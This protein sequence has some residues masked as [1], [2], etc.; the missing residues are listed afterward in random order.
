MASD[1][2]DPLERLLDLVE[3]S[4]ATAFA[5]A[6]EAAWAEADGRPLTTAEIHA[7]LDR[8][9]HDVW[10]DALRQFFGADVAAEF[11]DGRKPS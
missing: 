11:Y 6:L 3:P 9:L 2:L 4:F 7:L 10:G 5:S 1:R 8:A